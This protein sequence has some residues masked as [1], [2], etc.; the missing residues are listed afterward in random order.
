MIKFCSFYVDSLVYK[1]Q[2]LFS[3]CPSF[4]KLN[5]GFNEKRNLRKNNNLLS[6]ILQWLRLSKK[7]CNFRLSEKKIGV[8]DIN[9]L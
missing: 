6:R 4:K 7:F 1:A 3:N 8:F 5:T 2:G 9:G